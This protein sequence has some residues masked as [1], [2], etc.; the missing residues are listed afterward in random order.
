[1]LILAVK[2]SDANRPTIVMMWLINAG[3]A[4]KY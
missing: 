2:T 3:S 1:V 4:E